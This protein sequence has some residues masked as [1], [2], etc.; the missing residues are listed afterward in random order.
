M[1]V[2]YLSDEWVSAADDLLR[3][4]VIDPPI[5]G[6]PFSVETVVVGDGYDGAAQGYVVEF[7]GATAS[8]RRRRDGE[9]TTV[10]FTQDLATATAVAT[11]TVSAQA[12]FLAA[13]I[14]VGGDIAVLIANAGLVAQIGDLLGPLR[15]R[16]TFPVGS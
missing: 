14:Q 4:C 9:A 12:A 8:A 11:G 15:A 13:D 16:T 3:G 2:P 7:A 5:E 10:R 6:E 1:S